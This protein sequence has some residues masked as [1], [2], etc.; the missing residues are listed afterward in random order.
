MLSIPS[1][2]WPKVIVTYHLRQPLSISPGSLITDSDLYWFGYPRLSLLLPSVFHSYPFSSACC[3]SIPWSLCF[4]SCFCWNKK[5]R[6]LTFL[7]PADKT[8]EDESWLLIFHEHCAHWYIYALV[9]APQ[10]LMGERKDAQKAGCSSF[11][12]L[13][14]QSMLRSQDQSGNI[15]NFYWS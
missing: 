14:F 10:A 5:E 6:N 8:E 7:P 11:Q 3:R 9:F 2:L 4:C 1:D 13:S 15:H 12:G